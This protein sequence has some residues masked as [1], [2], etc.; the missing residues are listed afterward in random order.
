MIKAEIKDI[1]F[2]SFTRFSQKIAVHKGNT[3]VSQVDSLR[4]LLAERETP[5]SSNHIRRGY[6][7][8]RLNKNSDE[9]PIRNP[10][11]F[12]LFISD[13]ADCSGTADHR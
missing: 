13:R 5:F 8:D 3:S 9:F 10:S 4:E 1:Y 12:Y 7:F 11:E 6:F 2:E